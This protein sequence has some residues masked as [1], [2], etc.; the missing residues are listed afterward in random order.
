MSSSA[1]AFSP[2]FTRAAAA[3]RDRLSARLGKAKTK[4]RM[5][6]GELAAAEAD[7]AELEVRLA[8]LEPLLGE[9]VPG[10]AEA[11][12]G[13]RG[14]SIR[15]VAVEVLVRRGAD[16]GPIHYRR[17]LA[18][19]EAQA[20]PVAGK[21]PE[22]V[23]LNQVTRHPLVRATTKRGFYVLDPG[24]AE[25]LEAR[26]AELRSS[27]ATAT[28]AEAGGAPSSRSGRGSR[29]VAL[30]L[31]RAERELAEARDALPA[32]AGAGAR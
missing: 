8:A 19:V 26:V 24:A 11:P 21:R 27:L 32:G 25:R 7:V 13:L 2:R 5:R 17:W 6:K 20:G 29:Q 12:A 4:A 22:A 15:E 18:A 16:T 3:E 10:P 28:A 9:C 14:R 1:V 30:E 23:F 31:G